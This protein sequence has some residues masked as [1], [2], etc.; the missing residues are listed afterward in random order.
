MQTNGNCLLSKQHSLQ[1]QWF[2]VSSVSTFYKWRPWFG[3]LVISLTWLNLFVG[4]SAVFTGYSNAIMCSLLIISLTFS[5]LSS[6]FFFS[7][8]TCNISCC[9]EKFVSFLRPHKNSF[10]FRSFDDLRM[11]TYNWNCTDHRALVAKYE[12]C[13]FTWGLWRLYISSSRRPWFGT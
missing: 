11:F 13:R 6:I 3:T 12:T 10:F 5:A 2:V 1:T 7:A 8:S 4:G 9:W